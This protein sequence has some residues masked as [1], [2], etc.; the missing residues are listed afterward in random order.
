MAEQ[1]TDKQLSQTE[2]HS[3]EQ[4]RDHFAEQVKYVDEVLKNK[5][6]P[7][8]A[9]SEIGYIMHDNTAYGGYQNDVVVRSFHE[10]KELFDRTRE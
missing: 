5:F 2:I 10:L 4:L 3:L 1:I 8:K 7:M 6:F 9:E